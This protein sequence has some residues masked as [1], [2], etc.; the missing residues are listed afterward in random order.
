VSPHVLHFD[1]APGTTERENFT[2]R[3]T[4]TGTLHANVGPPKH[5]PPFSI[6]SNDGALTI[7]PGSSVTVTVQ[8]APTRQGTTFDRILITSNDPEH[9]KDT[10]GL[11]GTAKVPRRWVTVTS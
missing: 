9:K 3:N 11:K 8:Y 6:V 7:P 10:V 2:I 4:G 5:D 1:T